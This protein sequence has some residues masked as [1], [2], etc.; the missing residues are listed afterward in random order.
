[1]DGRIERP[2]P[3]CGSGDVCRSRR[4]GIV[5]RWLKFL[6]IVPFRCDVCSVR[7]FRWA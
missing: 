6:M 3:K 2:C 7:F 5:E 4:H 1:M